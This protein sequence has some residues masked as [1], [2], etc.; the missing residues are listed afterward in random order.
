MMGQLTKVE[1]QSALLI[2]IGIALIGLVLG[3][4]GRDDPLGVHG[5]LIVIAALAGIFKV[6]SIY[7]DPEPDEERLTRYYDDPTKLG[8]ILAMAWVVFGL[9]IGDWVAWLLV[10]PD[11]TFDGAAWASFG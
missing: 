9:F 10:K 6:I 2:L 5:A 1:R 11:L 8:V 4:A 3:I 7:F